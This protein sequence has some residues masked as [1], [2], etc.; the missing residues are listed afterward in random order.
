MARRI[1]IGVL[2]TVAL[3]GLARR[4]TVGKPVDLEVERG[5]VRASHRTVTQQVGPGAP[6]IEV[7]VRPAE[8]AVVSGVFGDPRTDEL[9][10]LAFERSDEEGLFQA[11]LPELPKGSRVRYAVTVAAPGGEPIR[12]PERPGAFVLLKY[13]GKAS[14][15]VLAAHIACMFGGFFCMVMSLFGAIRILRGREGKAGAVRFARWALLLSFIGGW[16]LGFVLNRETFGTLWEGYP[17]G[18]DVTDNKTQLMFVF[19][20]ASL[21]LVRGSF[22]GRNESADALPA[23]GFA[24]AI[25]TSFVVSL[26]LFVLP[27]SI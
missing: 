7:R 20:L 19:W 23:K 24:W 13:K 22:L 3:L 25:V 8:G 10:E 27:H 2:V 26:V 17:F 21:L 12:F 6:V 14:P 1:I 15:V 4:L 11:A 5:G 18:Y 16:P 9:G